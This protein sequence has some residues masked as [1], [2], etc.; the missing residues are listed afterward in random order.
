MT[1]TVDHVER[2]DGVLPPLQELLRRFFHEG[3]GE[4][5]VPLEGGYRFGPID[6]A[7]QEELF[8]TGQS[9]AKTLKQ[10]P[11]GRRCGLDLRPKGFN[12][13]R[14]FAHPSNAGM[15]EKFKLWGAHVRKHGPDLGIRWGGDFK[16]FGPYGDMPHAELIDWPKRAFPSGE[17][18]LVVVPS[19]PTGA[20]K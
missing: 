3:E 12:P 2:A 16:N 18:V 7:R 15:L 9:K 10:T 13:H 19:N 17:L 5:E 1:A 6:E 14:G 11:H 20:I 4:W 8:R